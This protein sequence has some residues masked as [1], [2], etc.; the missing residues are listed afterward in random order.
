MAEQA[1]M[2]VLRGLRDIAEQLPHGDKYREQLEQF[3]RA[4]ATASSG[5]RCSTSP[6]ATRR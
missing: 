2:E 6:V 3:G 1:A 5:M 4:P